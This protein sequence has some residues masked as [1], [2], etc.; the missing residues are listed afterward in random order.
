MADRAGPSPRTKVLPLLTE[1]DVRH[2]GLTRASVF[3]KK[4]G[5]PGRARQRRLWLFPLKRETL[6]A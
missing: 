2:A 4:N 1:F 6:R 3:L 5:L